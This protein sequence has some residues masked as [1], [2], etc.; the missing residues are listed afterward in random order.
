MRMYLEWNEDYWNTHGGAPPHK[1]E[2]FNDDDVVFLQDT[3]IVTKGTYYNKNVV[4]P[5]EKVTDD[6]IGY[7]QDVLEFKVPE[8]IN[9]DANWKILTPEE[10]QKLREERD[11][12]RKA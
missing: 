11:A 4:W 10:K 6:W 1:G 3:Y 8:W 12:K 2:P 5:K 9:N 7:C